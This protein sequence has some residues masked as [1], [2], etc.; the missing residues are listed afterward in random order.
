MCTRG[1]ELRAVL[2]QTKERPSTCFSYGD[3][4][5]N[6]SSQCLTSKL[7]VTFAQDSNCD[8][9]ANGIRLPDV[10]EGHAASFLF[11]LRRALLLQ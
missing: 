6:L 8:V 4:D 10:L 1:A 2:R 9:E 3:A 11:F 7:V 5:L